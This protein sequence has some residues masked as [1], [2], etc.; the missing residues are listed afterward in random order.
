MALDVTVIIPTLCLKERQHLLLRAL[1]SVRSQGATILV[2]V[3]GS[4]IHAP[5]LNTIAQYGEITILR[6]P[7]ADFIGAIRHGRASITSTTFAFLD[8][9]DI[10]LPDTLK[11]RFDALMGGNLDVLVVN[12]QNHDGLRVCSEPEQVNLDPI[13]ALLRTNWLASCAGIFRTSSISAEYFDH[14]M[15]YYEWTALAFNLALAGKHIHFLDILGY[16]LSDTP[17]SASKTRSATV[18]TESIRLLQGFRDRAPLRYRRSIVQK[19]AAEL[20]DASDYH[21]QHGKL[22]DAWRYHLQSLLSGGWSYLPYTR[23]LLV[24]L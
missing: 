6:I 7:D 4:R 17:N 11:L 18:F 3:N 9:D 22:A 23:H 2:V 14:L 21:R 20:H 16:Q 8:D 1:E 5:L 13:G 15:H 12:G 10:L 24:R 19:L